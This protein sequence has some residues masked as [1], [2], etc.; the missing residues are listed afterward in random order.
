MTALLAEPDIAGRNLK[1]LLI[2]GN[3]VLTLSQATKTLQA[4]LIV[5]G[6]QGGSRLNEIVL[7]SVTRFS[8]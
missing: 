5:A 3:P 2:H 8:R 4:D 7:G 6:K 1:S